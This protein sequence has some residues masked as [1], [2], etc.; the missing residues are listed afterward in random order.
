MVLT[1]RGQ[2]TTGK[3]FFL[4]I[5]DDAGISW[6]FVDGQKITQDNIKMF[7]PGYDGA[8]LPPTSL[9]QRAAAE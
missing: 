5:S 8:T 4:G 6:K 3:A 9:S 1:T 2:D 7:I